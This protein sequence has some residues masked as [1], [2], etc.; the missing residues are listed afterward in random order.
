MLQSKALGVFLEQ[1]EARLVLK[2][3][4]SFAEHA[5]TGNDHV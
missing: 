2:R 3:N 4:E 1:G 5:S